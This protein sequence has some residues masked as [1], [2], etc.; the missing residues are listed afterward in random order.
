MKCA[1]CPEEAVYV[2]SDPG[3]DPLYFCANDLPKHFETR[4]RA[5]HLDIPVPVVEVP[6]PKKVTPKP[7]PEAVDE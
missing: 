1:N 6:K 4:A 5:G 3:L 2:L 7:E